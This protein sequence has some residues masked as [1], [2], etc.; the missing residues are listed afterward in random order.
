MLITDDNGESPES[1]FDVR[2]LASITALKAYV[3]VTDK[4]DVSTALGALA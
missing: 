2:M 3:S 4:S 1:I